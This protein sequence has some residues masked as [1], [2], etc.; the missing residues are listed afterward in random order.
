VIQISVSKT[1][2]LKNQFDE[3]EITGD[4]TEKL[5]LFPGHSHCQVFIFACI[6]KVAGVAIEI[7]A[8]HSAV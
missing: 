3:L 5:A 1:L 4:Y 7:W 6:L 8:L 2:Y